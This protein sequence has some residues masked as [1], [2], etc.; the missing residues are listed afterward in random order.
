M[1][2]SLRL[3]K[4][5]CRGAVAAG[6]AP[7]L[8]KSCRGSSNPLL[9]RAG[10]R[11]ATGARSPCS[12]R[13]GAKSSCARPGGLIMVNSIC[14]R[15]QGRYNDSSMPRNFYVVWIDRERGIFTSWP[16]TKEQAH[17]FPHAKYKSF[18]MQAGAA[19]GAYPRSRSREG[20]RAVSGSLILEP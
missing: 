13:S 1:S 8:D 17:N 9:R 18:E 6:V 3:R 12:L 4:S 20:L 5:L 7:E 2:S 14:P 15:N 11:A 16:Y 19:A 10:A